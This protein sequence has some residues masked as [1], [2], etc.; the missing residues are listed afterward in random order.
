VYGSDELYLLAGQPLAEASFY[1][2]F[3]QIENGVGAVTALRKRVSEGITRGLPRLDGIRIGVVT[4]TSMA[5]LMPALLDLL[6]DACGARFVMIPAKNSLFGPTV[7]TAGLLVAADVRRVLA[8][9]R[10]VDA[11][12]IPAETL[13]DNGVFLDDVPIDVVRSEFTTPIHPSYDFVDVLSRPNV[14]RMQGSTAA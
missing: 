10:G 4:G 1:G 14:L 9:V 8:D 3:A 5:P 6:T 13:N 7:T 12:L 11:V 2:D